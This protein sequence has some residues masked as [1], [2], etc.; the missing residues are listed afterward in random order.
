MTFDR[1]FFANGHTQKQNVIDNE[2]IGFN[3]AKKGR[4]NSVI[5]TIHAYNMGMIGGLLLYDW[6]WVLYDK[7]ITWT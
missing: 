4:V 7:Y 5:V 6:L 1:T 3:T 2:L